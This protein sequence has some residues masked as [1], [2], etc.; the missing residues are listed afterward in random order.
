FLDAIARTLT[1]PDAAVS[2]QRRVLA[3]LGF[4]ETL[5]ESL[6]KS[7]QAALASSSPVIK[8]EALA[9]VLRFGAQGAILDT[10]A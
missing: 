3:A 9:V 6:H 4:M 2:V 10:V 1:D 8:T 7:L 5:P